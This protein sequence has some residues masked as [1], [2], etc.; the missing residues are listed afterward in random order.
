MARSPDMHG[1]SVGRSLA[2]HLLDRGSFVIRL[3]S[4]TVHSFIPLLAAFA[5]RW[6]GQHCR[7]L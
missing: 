3:D 1:E 5:K 6:A 4:H 7:L 2:D